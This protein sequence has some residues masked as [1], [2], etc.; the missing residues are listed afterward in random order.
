M[1]KK[2]MLMLVS[3]FSITMLF[4]CTKEKEA[5]V[6]DEKPK[7]EISIVLSGPKAPPTIPMLRMMQTKALG[8]NVKIS[9]KTWNSV[10]ELMAMATGSE[11]G[12]IAVPVNTSAKLYN[13]GLDVKLTNVNTWGVMYLA[14]TDEDCNKWADLKGEKLYVPFKTAPP[15]VITQY[16]LKEHGLEVGKDI[17]I[18]YSTPSE[19]AQ[20]LKADKIKYAMNIEPFITASKAGNEKVRVVFDYMKEWKKIKGN[21]YEIPN[22]GIIV[23][24]KAIKDNKE[25]VTLFEKEYEK[26]LAW[27][28]ENPEKAGELVEKYLG[29]NKTLIQ[30]SM[31]TL[32]LQYK[33]AS[34]S[35][36][37]LDEYYKTLLEFKPESIG[38]KI[39]DESYYYQ[40]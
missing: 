22:A 23:N 11:C 34:D 18:V 35:K 1:K 37:D 13:K 3:V 39:P 40:K 9:F 8:E 14:T 6:T 29:L 28:L 2:I 7:K 31:P 12:F 5:K 17:E 24:E 20:L 16:L 38:G 21:E 27:T 30:K 25:L 19:I 15:D 4:G 10:E 36:K 32:G 33:N 26:A